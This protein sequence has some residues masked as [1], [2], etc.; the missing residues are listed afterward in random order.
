V[1]GAILLSR[2][3]YATDD[4]MRAVRSSSVIVVPASGAGPRFAADYAKDYPG[5]DLVAD[6]DRIYWLNSSGRLYGFPRAALR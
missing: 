2:I 6:A 3:E 4:A 1:D 5:N